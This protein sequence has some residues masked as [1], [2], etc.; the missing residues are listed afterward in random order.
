MSEII[1]T[2]EDAVKALKKHFQKLN[3][4]VKDAD[5]GKLAEDYVKNNRWVGKSVKENTKSF[6]NYC[7]R[8]IAVD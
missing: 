3:G 7:A 6:L 1:L 5:L 2:S 4:L 8:R